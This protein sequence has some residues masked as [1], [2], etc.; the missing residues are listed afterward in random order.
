MSKRQDHLIV[1]YLSGIITEEENVELTHW[2]K[3]SPENE[4]KFRDYEGI[5]LSSGKELQSRTS[6][7]AEEWKRL[8]SSLTDQE[9]KVVSLG[10]AR[11]LKVAASVV[12]VAA[13][14][15]LFYFIA[16]KED[17]HVWETAGNRMDFVLQD[18]SHIWLNENSKL[19]VP[20]DFMENERTVELKGEAYFDVAKNPLK[21]FIIAAD[22]LRIKVLGTS[23]NVKAFEEDSNAEVLV[24]SGNV[25]VSLDQGP[26]QQVM[27][28]AGEK[29]TFD[30]GA[31]QLHK[32]VNE[33]LNE[34]AWKTKQLL[35][36]KTRVQEVINTVEKYFAVKIIVKNQ[37]LLKCRFTG[38]FDDP[39]LQE[40]LEALT[41]SL[42]LTVVREG[43]AF[44]VDGKGCSL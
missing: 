15:F 11:W 40:V 21:P 2:I 22:E 9:T 41:L 24:V 18:G 39:S 38:S 20:P 26:G 34:T 19:S 42:D 36:R 3:A 27:L 5:W 35:F 14:A 4:K 33:N 37:D 7:T 25:S 29:V 28:V 6:D 30:K 31:M 16:V 8:Q 17:T 13:S 32:G 23:F 12:L 1:K 44:V 43:D 10:T